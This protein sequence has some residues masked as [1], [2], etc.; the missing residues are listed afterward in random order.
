VLFRSTALIACP[1]R[2][3]SGTEDYAVVTL[4]NRSPEN[5]TVFMQTDGGQR[6]RIGDVP[7]LHFGKFTLG[8]SRIREIGLVQFLALT[9]TDQLA[10]FSDRVRLEVGDSVGFIVSR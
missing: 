6:Y 3:Y 1:H 5:L 7:A 2:G 8:E 9:Q 4:D 10:G